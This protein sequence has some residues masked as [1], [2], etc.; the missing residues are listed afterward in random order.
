MLRELA[1][2]GHAT[3]DESAREI[4]RERLALGLPP[5]PEPRDFAAE[6]LRRDRAKYE[7]TLAMAA[8]VFFDRGLVES[9][10]MAVEAAL[11][12]A[13]E[14]AELLR[15]LDFHRQ[16]FILPPWPE[17]YV[18]DAERDHGFDHCQRVHE[19]LMRWYPACG[20]RVQELPRASPRQRAE[21]LLRSLSGRG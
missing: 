7:A 17:I 11:L 18:V 12:S 10:A 1:A 21:H 3:V 5:R 2:L 8:P 15:P 4:I 13:A 19:A 14:A 20:Y 6:L 16:V 9:V